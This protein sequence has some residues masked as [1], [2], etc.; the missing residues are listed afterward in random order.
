MMTRSLLQWLP[1]HEMRD[2]EM[3]TPSVACVSKKHNSQNMSKSN[4]SDKA[5]PW[6]QIV[7]CLN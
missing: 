6:V 2:M 5:M 4:S 7:A 1:V 3:I